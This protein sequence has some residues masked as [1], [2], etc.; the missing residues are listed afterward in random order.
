[1]TFG[2]CFV[3]SLELFT[4]IFCLMLPE[5]PVLRRSSKWFMYLRTH[6]VIKTFNST[7]SFYYSTWLDHPSETTIQYDAFSLRLFVALGLDSRIGVFYWP[8]ILLL[9]KNIQNSIFNQPQG[10]ALLQGTFPTTVPRL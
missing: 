4:F 10:A 2:W 7:Y 5:L 9:Y 3:Y 1:M 8:L 6:Q